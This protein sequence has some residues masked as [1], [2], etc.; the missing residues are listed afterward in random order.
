MSPSL[1]YRDR[2]RTGEPIFPALSDITGQQ[3]SNLGLSWEIPVSRKWKRA[4]PKA[5]M[6]I[7]LTLACLR[8]FA[9]EL[10]E[11][12]VGYITGQAGI[13]HSDASLARAIVKLY[14]RGDRA[15]ERQ[16]K[17]QSQFVIKESISCTHRRDYRSN[18]P[19]L[20]QSQ[21]VFC[22]GG[23]RARQACVHQLE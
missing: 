19:G 14:R 22:Y 1:G 9:K 18:P 17:F 8:L 11:K 21:G 3:A 4:K 15:P 23:D 5:T 12:E 13:P 10:K 6:V 16:G 7:L 20:L 2:Q